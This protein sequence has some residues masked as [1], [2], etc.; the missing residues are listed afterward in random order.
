MIHLLKT[1]VELDDKIQ[2][3]RQRS[4]VNRQS[5]KGQEASFARQDGDEVPERGRPYNMYS[6]E[7]SPAG[8][9]PGRFS[10]MGNTDSAIALGSLVSFVT[11][12]R[13]GRGPS[14]PC[15]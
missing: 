14:G 4:I 13:R 11:V 3:L 8:D 7:D 5:T 9:E 12:W 6:A 10:A 15:S 1:I 2:A